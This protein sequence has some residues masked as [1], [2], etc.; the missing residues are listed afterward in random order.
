MF[1][2]EIPSW[3]LV[4]LKSPVK[5]LKLNCLNSKLFFSQTFHLLLL[6]LERVN[7][8]PSL[9]ACIVKGIVISVSPSAH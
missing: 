1:T 6:F 7:Y 4:K 9:R 3:P 8:E 2:T 5:N